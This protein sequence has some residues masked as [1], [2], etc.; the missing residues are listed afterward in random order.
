VGFDPFGGFQLKVFL[1]MV[2]PTPERQ[3]D[4]DFML[5][6]E[7]A[8]ITNVDKDLLDQIFDFMVRDFSKYALQLYHKPSSTQMQMELCMK[9]IRKPAVDEARYERVLSNHVYALKDVY[10]MN[11]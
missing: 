11:A 4:I 6:L 5:I 8:K 10:E 1:A 9:M 2:T 7:D 3:K